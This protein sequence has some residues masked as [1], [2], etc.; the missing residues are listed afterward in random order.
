MP[1]CFLATLYAPSP[2]VRRRHVSSAGAFAA[3]ECRPTC[4]RAR[5]GERSGNR[6]KGLASGTKKQHRNGTLCRGRPTVWGVRNRS[7]KK[8]RANANQRT[9]RLQ[10]RSTQRSSHRLD[11]SR[12]RRTLRHASLSL[13]PEKPER[14]TAEAKRPLQKP[15][16]LGGSSEKHGPS[17]QAHWLSAGQ[18]STPGSANVVC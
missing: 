12:M 4:P 1:S 9:Q 13:P 15:E 17:P 3:P 10:S 11:A 8:Y 7:P 2:R 18:I 16:L 5:A 14:R 6:N